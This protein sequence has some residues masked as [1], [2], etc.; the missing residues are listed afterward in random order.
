M[1]AFREARSSVAIQLH[2]QQQQGLVNIAFM[3]IYPDSSL[4]LHGGGRL[5]AFRGVWQ[6]LSHSS[7]T[8]SRSCSIGL[9]IGT[10]DSACNLCLGQ[11]WLRL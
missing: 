4:V 10:G 1:G 9:A 3:R 11:A 2:T 8:S 6:F 5:E 7:H